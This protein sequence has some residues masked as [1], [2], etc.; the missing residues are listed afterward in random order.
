M[1]FDTE[2]IDCITSF[3]QES[4]PCYLSIVAITNNQEIVATY[5]RIMQKVLAVICRMITNKESDTEWISREYLAKI[6]YSKYL[7]SV[8]M[9]FDLLTIYGRTNA[10]I[11]KKIIDIILKIEPKYLSDLEL[12]LKFIQKSFSTVQEQL[13]KNSTSDNVQL[14][15]DLCLHTLDC[16]TILSILMDVCTESRDICASINMDQTI[17]S[18]YDCF[19]PSLYKYIFIYDEMSSYLD[20]VNRIRVELLSSFRCI[21]NSYIE[22]VLEK[23]HQSLKSTTNLDSVEALL[24]IFTLCLSDNIFVIDYQKLYPVENDIEILRQACPKMDTF[25]ADFIIQAFL[26]G[27]ENN[28]VKLP[29]QLKPANHVN[30]CNVF[31]EEGACALSLDTDNSTV[32]STDIEKQIRIVQDILPDLGDGFVKKLLHRYDNTEL[33]IAAVLEGNLPP[34]LDACDKNEVYIPPDYQENLLMETGIRRI[35]VYDGD[36]YDVRINEKPRGIIKTG[37]GFPGQPKTAKDLLDDK[38]YVKELKSRYE[39]YSFV[40]EN[41]DYDDEYDDSYDAITESESK[42]T[43]KKPQSMR[44]VLVDEVEDDEESEDGDND[45][46]ENQN[47]NNPLNFCENPED[48]RARYERKRQQ[49]FGGPKKHSERDVV[50]KAKGQGQTGAVLMNR[51]KKEVNKSSRANHNRK[52]GSSW[53]KSRGM[54]PS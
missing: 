5:E 29:K 43:A 1:V 15:Y 27:D 40:M 14:L 17:T 36:D 34:D 13:E 53:K 19:I 11:L 47:K 48:V 54:I 4:T 37:K 7:I 25:K 9:I 31:E 2:S 38:S 30:G 23:N 8:P 22:K 35:N 32:L 18:I 10:C 33:A 12:A 50:G 42:K 6:I 16:T 21:I 51:H 24:S 49:K 28:F 41:C 52:Q 26:S 39:K 45:I 20:L 3:L 44:D 46:Q